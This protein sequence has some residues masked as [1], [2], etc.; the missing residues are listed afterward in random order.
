ML[1][2][3]VAEPVSAIIAPDSKDHWWSA[4]GAGVIA[5]KFQT[6]ARA[7]VVFD[8]FKIVWSGLEQMAAEEKVTTTVS[9]IM[10]KAAKNV[11]FFMAILTMKIPCRK[12]I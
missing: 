4:N 1:I 9:K 7:L 10:L 3:G 11:I 6:A 5:V 8:N 12:A 2:L